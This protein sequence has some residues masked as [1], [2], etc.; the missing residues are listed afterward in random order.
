MSEGNRK[1]PVMAR[2]HATDGADTCRGEMAMQHTMAFHHFMAAAYFSN[3]V[4]DL[5]SKY[6]GKGWGPHAIEVQWAFS[7]CIVLSYAAMES[8][9]NEIADRVSL[10][11]D[12]VDLIDRQDLLKKYRLLLKFQGLPPFNLGSEPAQ[13]VRALAKLRNAFV[14]FKPL[15]EHKEGASQI[16]EKLLPR[17]VESRFAGGQ[18][19]FFP[20]R[21]VSSG[22]SEWALESVHAFMSEFAVKIGSRFNLPPKSEWGQAK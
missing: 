2:L 14:H 8:Y 7:G 9:Y 10:D 19:L 22:Y 18:E 1:P 13:S 6:D 11:K 12:F 21:C 5:E 16:L 4:K 15:W 3:L 17:R 20:R